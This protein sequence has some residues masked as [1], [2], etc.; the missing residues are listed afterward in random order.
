MYDLKNYFFTIINKPLILLLYHVTQGILT[1]SH[2][3]KPKWTEARTLAKFQ[4]STL[5]RGGGGGVVN[6]CSTAVVVV[7]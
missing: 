5:L 1:F 7:V 2:Q 3:G 4:H 6:L